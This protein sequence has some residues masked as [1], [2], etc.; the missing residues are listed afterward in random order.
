[1]GW[2]VRSA[3]LVVL[4]LT[5]CASTTP[6]TDAPG[7]CPDPPPDLSLV[8]VVTAGGFLPPGFPDA[9][10]E[11]Y[12]ATLLDA[13]TGE[14]LHVSVARRSMSQESCRVTGVPGSRAPD[15]PVTCGWDGT[16][17]RR[18]VGDTHGYAVRRGDLLVQ[19]GGSRTEIPLEV[20]RGAALGARPATAAEIT[21]LRLPTPTPS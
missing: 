6:G 15:T 9:T 2:C 1:M 5:G 13:R 21:G 18:D 4:A 10:R 7:C 19:T 8:Y 16:G 12:A 17:W 11:R 3:A 20:L 14:E